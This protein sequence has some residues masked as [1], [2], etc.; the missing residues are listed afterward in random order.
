MS[1]RVLT[2]FDP[3]KDLILACDASPY[4]VG[5]V[6]S[7]HMPDGSEN[8]IAYASRTMTASERTY[9]QIDKDAL[10]IIYGVKHFDQY[11][12]GKKFTLVT[13]HKPLITLLSE[14]KAVPQT[15]SPRLIRWSLMLSGYDYN[16]VY[17]KG[18]DH[19]NSFIRFIPG[20]P[21]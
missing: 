16:T 20:C 9:S 3:T 4:A 1:E 13:E 15:A 12:F 19:A 11:L 18:N 6:L 2:H 14:I 5:C 17:H 7:H 21:M 10:S 8:P